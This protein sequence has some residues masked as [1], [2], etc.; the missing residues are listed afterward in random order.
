MNI[1]NLM[2]MTELPLCFLIIT[3]FDTISP[4]T[5]FFQNISF[6]LNNLV[7][8]FLLILFEQIMFT[9]LFKNNV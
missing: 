4:V 3:F 8:I 2:G 7:R 6:L 1:L 5:F 9:V